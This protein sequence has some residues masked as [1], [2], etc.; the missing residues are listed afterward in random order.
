MKSR[1]SFA[2]TSMP[3]KRQSTWT[4]LGS[5]GIRGGRQRVGVTFMVEP[6]VHSIGHIKGKPFSF[7]SCFH[8][9][10]VDVALVWWRYIL[11]FENLEERRGRDRAQLAYEQ[12]DKSRAG[13][14][15]P[16]PYLNLAPLQGIHAVSSR[17]RGHVQ[18]N[19]TPGH[20]PWKTELLNQLCVR[21]KV[22]GTIKPSV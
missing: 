16:A 21:I 19:I 4:N 7:G 1:R 15:L 22:T 6:L 10:A 8:D 14:G 18:E 13:N 5:L 11:G 3:V 12:Q 20:S 9:F 17:K 2:C